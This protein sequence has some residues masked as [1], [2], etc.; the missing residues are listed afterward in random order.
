M[1]IDF[2]NLIMPKVTAIGTVS[3]QARIDD[4]FIWCEISFEAL[5]DQFGAISVS[6]D[7]LLHAFHNGR[8]KIEET[9]RRQLEAGGGRPVLLTVADF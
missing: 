8:A 4:E 5:V 3:F 7:D 6:S 9:A 2:P 1:K